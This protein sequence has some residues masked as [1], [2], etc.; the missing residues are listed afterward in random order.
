MERKKE[1]SRRVLGPSEA[2]VL[3]LELVEVGDFRVHGASEGW[4]HLGSN[5]GPTGYEPAALTD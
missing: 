4:A 1:K 5:Q 2:L 3:S